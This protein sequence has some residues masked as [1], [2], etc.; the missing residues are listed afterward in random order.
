MMADPYVVNISGNLI[1]DE[2]ISKISDFQK[3]ILL[4]P[5]VASPGGKVGQCVFPAFLCG[6]QLTGSIPI[7]PYF[8]M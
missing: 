6:C 3:K 7:F 2:T 5:S 4:F 1:S 8:S